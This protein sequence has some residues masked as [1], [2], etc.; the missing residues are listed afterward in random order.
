MFSDFVCKHFN[1]YPRNMFFWTQN[2][3]LSLCQDR[4]GGHL[5]IPTFRKGLFLKQV[6]KFDK[7]DTEN[8]SLVLE[9]YCA[10]F[11]FFF[12]ESTTPM[13]HDNRKEHTQLNKYDL[14]FC[15]YL[16]HVTIP[17][18]QSYIQSSLSNKTFQKH[19]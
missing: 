6:P 5:A 3:I 17:I 11:S 14:Y 2:N 16:I 4:G 10:L 1:L 12:A 7:K 8:S 19:V 13:L 18:I 15:I 9:N